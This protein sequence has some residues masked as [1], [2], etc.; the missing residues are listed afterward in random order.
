MIHCVQIIE[1]N[2]QGRQGSKKAGRKS[3]TVKTVQ[4]CLAAVFLF[5]GITGCSPRA[6]VDIPSTPPLSRSVLGYGVVNAAYIRV[7][8]EPDQNGVT[9]GFVREKTVLTIL[10]RRLVKSGDTLESWIL[11]E[12]TN[13]GSEVSGGWLPESVIKLYDNFD[14]AQTAASQ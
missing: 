1:A 6:R 7:L 8:D 9:L 11:T 3:G 12:G 4:T 2:A 5:M 13:S 10:E 14:R